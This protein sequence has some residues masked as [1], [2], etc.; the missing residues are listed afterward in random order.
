MYSSSLLCSCVVA[1]E[2]CVRVLT[3]FSTKYAGLRC[4]AALL[5][6]VSQSSRPDLLLH[7]EVC[8]TVYL[9]WTQQPFA[10]FRCTCLQYLSLGRNTKK[11]LSV[12]VRQVEMQC[13]CGLYYGVFVG[14]VLDLS[15]QYDSSGFKRVALATFPS[16]SVGVECVNLWLVEWSKHVIRTTIN[17]CKYC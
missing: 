4:C 10:I 5:P 2:S 7:Q 3:S 12:L 17:N 11:L 8:T 1:L 13:R 6:R 15:V 9:V 16:I 14:Y